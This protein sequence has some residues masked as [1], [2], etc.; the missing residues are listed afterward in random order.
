[1]RGMP[2]QASSSNETLRVTKQER[3]ASI[4]DQHKAGRSQH[5]RGK[6]AWR[7]RTQDS[8]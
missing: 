8:Q 7:P 6:Y 5:A 1:M 4:A 2:R 3:G